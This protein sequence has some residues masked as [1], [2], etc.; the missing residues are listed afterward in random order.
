MKAA[1][2]AVC[3]V[4]AVVW[5]TVARTDTGPVTGGDDPAHL[6]LDLGEDVE[7]PR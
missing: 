3:A 7:G 4:V 5:T 1:V 2:L 6:G